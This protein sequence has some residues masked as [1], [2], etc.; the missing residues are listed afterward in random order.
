M[1]AFYS[2]TI[3]G[4]VQNLARIID[5]FAP[6]LVDAGDNGGVNG[7]TTFTQGGKNCTGVSGSGSTDIGWAAGDSLRATWI[8]SNYRHS[9]G[10]TRQ[11]TAS[12][13]NLTTGETT[14]VTKMFEDYATQ[15]ADYSAWPDP[16]TTPSTPNSTLNPSIDQFASPFI[17]H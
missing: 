11:N 4:G 16:F 6:L 10:H 3:E 1:S 12:F 8:G 15:L 5:P 13:T 17:F 14:A 9:G 2:R 7:C